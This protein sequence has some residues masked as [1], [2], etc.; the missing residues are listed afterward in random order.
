MGVLGNG[1]LADDPRRCCQLSV[2]E[3]S[4]T[5]VKNRGLVARSRRLDLPRAVTCVLGLVL[6]NIARTQAPIDGWRM[7]S[8]LVLDLL[9]I[10][11]FAYIELHVSPNPLLPFGAVNKDIG[12]VL[13]AVACG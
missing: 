2:P 4:R 5:P 12:F 8:V 10:G 6:F 13:A 3:L 1:N 11:V 7:P 9:F